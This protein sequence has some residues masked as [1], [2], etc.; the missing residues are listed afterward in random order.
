MTQQEP[1]WPDWNSLRVFADSLFISLSTDILY[2][3]TRY[4]TLRSYTHADTHAHTDLEVALA[5][6]SAIIGLLIY[7]SLS[8]NMNRF[9][10]QRINQVAKLIEVLLLKLSQPKCDY[11][12]WDK[13]SDHPLA[14]QAPQVWCFIA[15]IF[16]STTTTKWNCRFCDS[17]GQTI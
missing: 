9:L 16:F 3:L 10:I 4:D 15:W 14:L 7:R 12:F 2:W 1:I 5:A 6:Q 8:H 13:V 17:R 11:H